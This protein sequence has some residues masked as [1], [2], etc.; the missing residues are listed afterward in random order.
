V[1]VLPEL[2]YENIL[3]FLETQF[4]R[5]SAAPSQHHFHGLYAW[6][7][8]AVYWIFHL[9]HVNNLTYIERNLRHFDGIARLAEKNSPLWIF[10]LNHDLII[11]CLAAAH[12]IPLNSGFT[13]SVVA[14]PRRNSSGVKT[15]EL[16][17]EVITGDQLEK[18]GM[19][20]LQP[21][22]PGINLLKIHGALDVFTF[23]NGNDLLKL[24]PVEKTVAGV[25]ETLRAANEELISPSLPMKATNEIV[26]DDDGGT[27]PLRSRLMTLV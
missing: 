20:F 3:G 21:G 23:R 1:L 15:G 9:R 14:L 25:I 24:L 5:H 16:R 10:S 19:P 27:P 8:E 7:V 26:Y 18:S 22:T 17:A 6:L 2:H 12:S 13:T 11:E 4:R